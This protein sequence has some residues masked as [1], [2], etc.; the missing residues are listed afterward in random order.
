MDEVCSH[1]NKQ[2]LPRNKH[3]EKYVWD[4]TAHAQ[5]ACWCESV[6]V[7]CICHEVV[8]R[9]TFR[10]NRGRR[11]GM[12]DVRTVTRLAFNKRVEGEVRLLQKSSTAGSEIRQIFKLDML[13]IESHTDSAPWFPGCSFVMGKDAP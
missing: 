5:P 6:H 2:L 1:W 13:K 7:T 8:Y 10:K 9:R 12:E 3:S 4:T 11:T